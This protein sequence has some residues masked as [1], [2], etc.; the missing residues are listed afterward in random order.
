MSP[1]QPGSTKE[2]II[3]SLGSP[4]QETQRDGM[5]ILWYESRLP[6]KTTFYYLKDDS[7]GIISQA[8][9]VQFK[10]F[11]EYVDFYGIPGLAVKRYGNEIVLDTPAPIISM[12]PEKGLS[13]VSYGVDARSTLERE[14]R[15][16]PTTLEN[17]LATWGKDLVGH[18]EVTIASTSTVQPA[19]TYGTPQYSGASV[20]IWAGI[21]IGILTLL[22]FKR[23]K[24]LLDTKK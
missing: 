15:F 24:N 16:I 20:W 22:Y 11:G 13:I 2:Q 23:R 21:G 4:I 5:T 1:I 19:V 18:E 7:L 14:E 9:D 6:S 8:K 12:W 17:Y 10:T 3:S